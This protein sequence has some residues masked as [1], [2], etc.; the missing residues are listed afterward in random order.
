MRWHPAAPRGADPGGA[1]AMGETRLPYGHLSNAPAARPRDGSQIGRRSLGFVTQ[2]SITGVTPLQ[3]EMRHGAP[4]RRAAEEILDLVRVA[5]RELQL[6]PAFE[7]EEVLA[8]HVGTKTPDEVQ[9][10]DGRAV[11]ALKELRIQDL[12]ELLH[13]AAQDVGIAGRVDAH[14]VPGRVDPLDRCHGH[15]HRLATLAD[16]QH[17]GP[18]PVDRLASTFE[19]LIERQLTAAGDLGDDLQ[20]SVALIGGGPGTHV[21]AHP[22]ERRG[23]A[24]IVDRLQQVVDRARFERLD[25]VLVVGGDE[26]Q[27]RLVLLEG[28]ECFAAPGA[29]REDL[30]VGRRAQA[31]LDPAP[32]QS[33][34]IDDDGADLHACAPR[35]TPGCSAGGFAGASPPGPAVS[36]GSAMSTRRPGREFSTAKRQFSPYSTA[37]RSRVLPRPTPRRSPGVAPSRRP[38]PSSMTDSSSSPSRVRPSMRTRPP[39]S[40]AATAY[41]S[42]FSSNGCSSRLGTRALS[43][44]SSIAYS[45]RSRSPKRSRSVPRYRSSASSSWRRVTFFIGSWSRV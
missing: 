26:H 1:R 12:L 39:C 15:A 23:E 32:R 34:V 41:F 38:G 2:V 22:R 42:E 29:L 25:G 27:V 16:R 30:E 5:A 28:R 35:A 31:E 4:A 45:S 40:R 3:C 14:V 21:L 18:P 44:G 43:A 13:G 7:R 20:Q 11:H 8:V 10:D 9:V 36:S 6:V 19:Q 33:L 37:R 17:L 24:H